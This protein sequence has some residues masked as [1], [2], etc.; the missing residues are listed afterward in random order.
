MPSIDRAIAWA[1][2]TANDPSHGYSM[3]NRYGP[4]YDCSSFVAAAL[5]A[6]GFAVPASM[7]TPTEKNALLNVGF[8]EVPM[9]DPQQK[10]DIYINPASGEHGHTCMAINA[11]Q[12]VE[13]QGGDADGMPG[14]SLGVEIRIIPMA[15]YD[16][17]QT[18]HMRWPGASGRVAVWHNKNWG[19]YSRNSDEAKDNAV[20]VYNALFPYGW[21]INAVAGLLGNI[22]LECG[23]NPWMWQGGDTHDSRVASTDTT[24]LNDRDHGYGLLQFTPSANYCLSSIAQSLTYFGPNYLDIAGNQNDG[25]A[26]CEFIHRTQAGAYSSTSSYPETYEQYIASTQDAAYL[27]AAWLYNYQRPAQPLDTLARRQAE[28]TYWYQILPS[29]IAGRR[30]RKMPIIFYLSRRKRR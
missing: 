2:A 18:I 30:G 22:G 11:T 21:T 10:G 16:F 25:T 28:A 13:A 19:A 24:A 4:D 6:G 15:G 1:I 29:L 7:T 12:I 17:G 27:A 9:N 26:Q 20:M 23:Y 5:I 8:V 3:I 14:D